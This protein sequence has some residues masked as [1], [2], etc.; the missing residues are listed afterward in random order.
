METVLSE[1]RATREKVG[2]PLM[3]VSMISM[4]MIFAGLTSAY[5]VRMES[6]DW[7]T[8]ELPKLFYIS[9]ALILISSITMN[10]T[11][12]SIKAGNL[13]GMKR[14]ALITLLLGIGFVVTQWLAWEFLYE[15][16]IVF[17]GKHSNASGSFLY[18]LT[19][20]HALHLIA[21]IL[22]LTFV[23]AKAMRGLYSIDNHYGVEITAIFWHF[24]DALWIF[25]FLFLL[26]IR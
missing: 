13:A 16:R 22:S 2:K 25:L 17:A 21:G 18:I 23:W 19:G 12:S 7:M 26:F 15:N 1:E 10:T 9:T 14:A 3:W 20:L 6:G 8:F 4:F 24:L 11:V 5:Y